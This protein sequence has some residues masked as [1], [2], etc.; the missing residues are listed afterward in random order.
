MNIKNVDGEIISSLSDAEIYKLIK[1]DYEF[2]DLILSKINFKEANKQIVKKLYYELAINLNY[3]INALYFNSIIDK[4]VESNFF[5]TSLSKNNN[6]INCQ[7]WSLIYIYFL[8]YAGIDADLIMSN[9][10]MYVEIK[11]FRKNKINADVTNIVNTGTMKMADLNRIKYGI[12]P[13][14][15]TFNNESIFKSN[16]E[17][18]LKKNINSKNF[19]CISSIETVSEII[20]LEK[21]AA[22][23]KTTSLEKYSFYKEMATQLFKRQINP[24]GINDVKKLYKK[25]NNKLEIVPCF[26]K[27]DISNNHFQKKISTYFIVDEN[28]E[29]ADDYTLRQLLYSGEYLLNPGPD[30]ALEEL[31]RIK[32]K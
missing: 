27:D 26:I 28:I 21:K 9:N 5:S 22:I 30:K 12:N 11:C 24:N 25:V 6:K 16:D 31:K 1:I 7:T 17:E 15:I 32:I 20:D 29:V 18:F 14:N 4:Y 2:E 8:I 10:H 3:D 23:T 13:Q 19:S